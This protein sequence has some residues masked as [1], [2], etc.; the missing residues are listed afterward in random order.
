MVNKIPN[1]IF[2]QEMQNKLSRTET[3]HKTSH[4]WIV[5]VVGIRTFVF[6]NQVRKNRLNIDYLESLTPFVVEW[7]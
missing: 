5:Y 3:K 1:R 7:E 6:L 4:A 2:N